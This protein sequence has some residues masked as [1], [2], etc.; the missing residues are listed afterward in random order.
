MQQVQKIF[1]TASLDSS[2][3]QAVQYFSQFLINLPGSS[4]VNHVAS[5]QQHDALVILKMETEIVK[6]LQGI[7]D[8]VKF[9]FEVMLVFIQEIEISL[10]FEE[11]RYFG[12][13]AFHYTC[14]LKTK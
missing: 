7:L 13:N 5:G 12:W 11:L 10:R 6:F 8:G 9:S 3:H 1:G 4:P 14:L 2:D